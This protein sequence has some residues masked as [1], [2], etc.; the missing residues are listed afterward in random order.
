[1]LNEKWQTYVEAQDR[2]LCDP[3]YWAQVSRDAAKKYRAAKKWGKT[4]RTDALVERYEKSNGRQINEDGRVYML[5]VVDIP[6]LPL[7]VRE[8]PASVVGAQPRVLFRV[9]KHWTGYIDNRCPG[10]A[11]DPE[12]IVTYKGSPDDV[13]DLDVVAAFCA[14]AGVH[15]ATIDMLQAQAAAIAAGFKAE[16]A[17]ADGWAVFSPIR[18][19]GLIFRFAVRPD[20]KSYIA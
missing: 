3:E 17:L 18:D 16:T 10:N 1:M 14:D 9:G 5:S 15:G 2:K 7:S 13:C 12:I 20:T 19:N 11:I 8:E 6:G 4:K